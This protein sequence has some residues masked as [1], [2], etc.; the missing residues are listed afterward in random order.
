M[1]PSEAGRRATEPSCRAGGVLARGPQTLAVRQ[2]LRGAF[3]APQ[4]CPRPSS[5][6]EAAAH[7]CLTGHHMDYLPREPRA[8][9]SWLSLVLHDVQFWVPVAV[10]AC[11]LL[12]LRWI[13]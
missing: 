2:A 1:Y 3:V 13:S 9:G 5:I 4:Y 10:L 12:V 7:P 11:G 8:A 6:R